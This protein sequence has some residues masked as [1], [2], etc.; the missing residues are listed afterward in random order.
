MRS[1]HEAKWSC[2]ARRASVTG[3][4]GSNT[5]RPLLAGSYLISNTLKQNIT[6]DQISNLSVPN[7]YHGSFLDALKKHESFDQG[8]VLLTALCRQMEI[9]GKLSALGISS[10]C[11]RAFMLTTLFDVVH[12]CWS[13]KLYTYCTSCWAMYTSN[14]KWRSLVVLPSIYNVLVA[15]QVKSFSKSYSHIWGQR[16]R[17][18]DGQRFIDLQKHL[19]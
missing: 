13:W 19:Q 9:V 2:C 12:W 7:L 5:R 18:S 4:K 8:S 16:M 6:N 11:T 3:T 14:F 17:T 15:L 10:R 1:N